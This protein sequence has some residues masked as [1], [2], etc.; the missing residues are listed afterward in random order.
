[1]PALLLAYIGDAVYDLHVRMKTASLGITSTNKLHR[2][3]VRYVSARNQRMAFERIRDI[4]D[5]KESAVAKRG[6]NAKPGTIPKNADPADYSHATAL[7]AVIGYLFLAGE[8]A[9][10]AELFKKMEE[11]HDGT[12]E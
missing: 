9:R 8:K 12:A 7:E 3:A 6:R 10:L 1:M 4:L 2:E 5:E 11:E